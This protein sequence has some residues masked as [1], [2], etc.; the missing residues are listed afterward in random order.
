MIYFVD[1]AR[2]TKCYCGTTMGKPGENEIMC[3]V[4]DGFRNT[5]N[6]SVDEWCVGPSKESEAIEFIDGLC[7]KGIC[8]RCL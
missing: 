7:A 5:R 3:E 4:D 2:T 8:K 1:I 6:C